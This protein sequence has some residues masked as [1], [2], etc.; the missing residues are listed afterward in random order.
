MSGQEA[1]VTRVK[2]FQAN[3]KRKAGGTPALNTS[4]TSGGKSGGGNGQ[5]G[6][7]RGGN[8]K[9]KHHGVDM[10][11]KAENSKIGLSSSSDHKSSNDR[12][13]GAKHSSTGVHRSRIGFIREYVIGV[14]GR[15]ISMLNADNWYP[16]P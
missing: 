1:E 2:S 4:L 13:A 5:G 6:A 14:E 12:V 9:G 16:C 10:V 11:V 8:K 7:G 15:G 3:F